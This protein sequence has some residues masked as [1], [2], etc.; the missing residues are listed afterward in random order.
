MKKISLQNRKRT[1]EMS[2]TVSRLNQTKKDELLAL[3]LESLNTT[4][5][6]A[7]HF[8]VLSINALHPDPNQPRK[9][10]KN[11]ENLAASIK[12]QGLLQP[13]V[14]KPLGEDAYKI[15]V[16]ERRYHAAKLAGLTEISA[17][18]RE[19]EDADTLILQ[20]LENDQRDQVSPLEEA[21]ALE[22]LIEKMGLT[23]QAIAKELGRDSHW[24]SMRLGLIH[25]NPQIKALIGSEKIADLRTLHELRKLSEEE[26]A[27]FNSVLR[28]INSLDFSGSYRDL[29][30]DTRLHKKEAIL[31]HVL[32]AEY[33]EG[34]LSLFL[35]GKRK[36]MLFALDAEILK[37]VLLG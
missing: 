3:K 27:L 33:H 29:I 15:I 7:G 34:V 28:K 32:K 14:V 13:I 12:E 19:E 20:L 31:P 4:A 26:P 35:A 36:P 16:G 8:L 9:T 1:A 17:I 30:R 25:A 18:I 11:I 5:K 24:I 10:F 22:K 21:Q 37:N 6:K 23:K 2:E